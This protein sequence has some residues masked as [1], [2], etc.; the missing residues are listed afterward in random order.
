MKYISRFDKI[1]KPHKVH[2]IIYVKITACK[3]MIS[4]LLQYKY[5]LYIGTSSVI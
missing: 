5:N 4:F 1:K 2:N 3:A